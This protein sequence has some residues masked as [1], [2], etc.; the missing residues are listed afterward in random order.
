ML[1]GQVVVH[2]ETHY[3]V[4]AETSIKGSAHPCFTG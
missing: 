1:P 4:V 3:F 2:K